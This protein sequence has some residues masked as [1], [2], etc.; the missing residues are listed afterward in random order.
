MSNRGQKRQPG[1]SRGPQPNK[2]QH[3][4]GAKAARRAAAVRAARAKRRRQTLAGAFAA[5]AVIG[6]IV[7]G[8]VF[9]GDGPADREPAAGSTDAATE[10]TTPPFPLPEGADPAL[11][12]RPTATAGTGELTELTVTPLIEGKGAAAENG[13]MITVNYLGVSYRTGEEFDASWNR[14]KPFSFQLGVGNVIEGWD[15]GLVGAKV[16]SRVQLDI[17]AELAYGEHGNPSGP[18]RFIVDVLDVR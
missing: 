16:G 14:P 6:V 17:P 11:G 1:T 15:Q 7:A 3:R 9:F 8:F 4:S 10:A 18:L 5:L 2:A 13:Q 12:T